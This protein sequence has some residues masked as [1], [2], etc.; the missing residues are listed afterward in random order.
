MSSKIGLGIAA[1]LLLC[2]VPPFSQSQSASKKLPE[3]NPKPTK[4]QQS[5][6]SFSLSSTE[7]KAVEAAKS[8]LALMDAG[9]YG[10]AWDM[11]T[12]NRQGHQAKD[13]F[14]ATNTA[15]QGFGPLGKRVLKY[16][17]STKQIQSLPDGE[18]VVLG[19]EVEFPQQPYH[20][21]EEHCLMAYENGAWR[22]ELFTAGL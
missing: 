16:V 6:C 15:R 4:L 7:V 12:V 17:H 1:F 5:G 8:F 3:L 2:C 14:I 9:K 11:E 21:M 10:D 20:F 22:V 13:L 19:F 18:Y